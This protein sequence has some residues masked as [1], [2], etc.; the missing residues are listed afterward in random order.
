VVGAAVKRLLTYIG[1]KHKRKINEGGMVLF[2]SEAAA[3]QI[4]HREGSASE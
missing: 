4:P 1:A 2:I 3:E